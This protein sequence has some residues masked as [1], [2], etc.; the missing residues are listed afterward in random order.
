MK[1]IEIRLVPLSEVTKMFNISAFAAK[2][3]INDGEIKGYKIG[4]NW[5]VDINSCYSYLERCSA[6]NINK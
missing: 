3:L 2:K 4:R 5:R 1:D 6:D